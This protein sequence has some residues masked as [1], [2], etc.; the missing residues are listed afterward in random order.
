MKMKKSLI[1]VALLAVLGSSL[2]A[3]YVETRKDEN[4]WRLIVDNKPFEVKGVVWAFTPIG[5]TYTYNLFAQS[6]DYIMKMID[7]DMVLLKGMGVNTIRCFSTIP[8][9]WIEYIYGKYGI[10][11]MVNDLMGRY[12]VSVNGKWFPQTDYSD[13]NTRKVLVAQAKK[14]AQTYRGTKGVLMYM[15]GNESNYGLVWSG[16]NIENLPTGEQNAV[17]AGYLYSLFEEAMAACKDIDPLR[18]VGLINGDTQYLDMIKTLCPSIDILG[19][20]AYRGYKFYDSFYQGIAESLDKPVVLTEAGADAFNTLLNQEDQTGQAEYLKSQWNEMYQNSYGKGKSGNIVGGYVFEWIDEWWKHF[21]TKNLS[22]HDTDGTWANAGYDI[23]YRIGVNNMQEE[24]F[25]IVGQSKL[26][27][28]GINKRI[29]RAAYYLLSDIWKLSLYDATNEEV[30]ASFAALDMGAYVA[31][32]NETSVKESISEMKALSID[33]VDLTVGS[34]AGI[35]HKA[36]KASK[37]K[38]KQYI[39][40]KP[41]AETALGITAKPMES[42]TASTE[43]RVWTSPR[44]TKLEEIYPSYAGSKNASLYSAS[45]AYNADSFD[46]NGYYHK[47]HANF[48]T[49]GDVFNISKE[50]FDII[51]Y[52]T[53]GSA[54][55]IALE[56]VGKG[57]ISGLQIIGGP[58]LWG[59]AKPQI[60]ANYYRVFPSGSV[61]FPEFSVGAVYSEEFG[62]STTAAVDP[63][64]TYGPG[65]KA[66]L[67]GTARLYPFV[68]VNAGILYAGNEKIGAKY[69]LKD[70]LE[71][72]VTDID[73]LGGS[74]EIGSEI[75]RHTYVYGKYIYRGL[76]ADTNAALVRGGFFSGDSGSGNRQEIQA[77]AEVNYGDF[78]FKPVARARVPIVEANGRSLSAVYPSPFIVYGNRQA[79]EF[80]AVLTYDPEGATWFH[81]WNIKDIEGAK[82]AASLTGLYTLYAGK[83]DI[84]S[85]KSATGT[86]N[87]M[88]IGLPAQNNLWQV[89]TKVISS[90][91]SDLKVI[92]GFESGHQGSTG[93][94]TDI[95]DFWSAFA[96]VRYKNLIASGTYSKDKWGPEAWWRTF[97]MTFPAQWQ[98]DVGYGFGT[99]SFLEPTNRIGLKWQG[100]TFGNALDSADPWSAVTAPIEDKTYSEVTVYFNIRM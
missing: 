6:D 96:E 60:M 19:V 89:G 47:G 25:G 80:E 23:D 72:T 32:G 4:G 43:L 82:F 1:M 79:V 94:R 17:K 99:P 63:Y 90:P 58:E 71:K 28:D 76:V 5:E 51:G 88:A 35:D 21:Q 68:K 86:W 54:A 7:T 62:A 91:L 69:R 16:T 8:P 77:G 27:E 49:T 36:M 22:V 100:R 48:E 50:A 39:N 97:N 41:Y 38:W 14:T 85:Y 2:F 30:T 31:K 70:G 20:N 53:Y 9:R 87:P 46:L 84:M 15:F 26:T 33:Y 73:T 42:L 11:T 75:L 93:E 95:V 92:G 64:N 57:I 24:W 34:I 18:P 83:T 66:S 37:D 3:Q 59:G 29:P 44:R 13:L 67:Y 56:L 74:V 65:R 45:F 78:S 52:D 12:G 55:P 40:P 81:D 61:Y 10:Y 98:L